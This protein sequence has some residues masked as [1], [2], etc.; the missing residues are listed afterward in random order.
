MTWS[1]AARAAA[2]EAR[3][4]HS[5]GSK[6]ASRISANLGGPKNLTVSSKLTRS[7]KG[8]AALEARI[9]RNLTPGGYAQHLY[10]QRRLALGMTK[11]R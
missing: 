4:R 1:D 8:R 11:T 9:R 5:T 3:R 10:E 7:A 6:L 2:L